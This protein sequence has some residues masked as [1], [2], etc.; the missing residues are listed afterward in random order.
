MNDELFCCPYGHS[1]PFLYTHQT[2]GHT[3][4]QRITCQTCHRTFTMETILT[5]DGNNYSFYQEQD[6][7]LDEP[8]KI[9]GF[10]FVKA[11]Q[12]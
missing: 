6:G 3:G 12:G 2:I 9:S 8:V 7:S 4:Y 11:E 1:S 5:R 10:R